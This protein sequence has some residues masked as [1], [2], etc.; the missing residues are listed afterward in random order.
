M[1]NGLDPRAA[2][3]GFVYDNI[4]VGIQHSPFLTPAEKQQLRQMLHIVL[5]QSQS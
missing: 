3:F 4:R 5:V 2:D 1:I